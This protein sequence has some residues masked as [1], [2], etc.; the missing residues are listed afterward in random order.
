M[1]K[2]EYQLIQE[3]QHSH[4]WWLGRKAIL[5]RIIE[6]HLDLEKKLLI[7]DVGC[8]F[9]ANIPMLRQYGD[10]VGLELNK[11]ALD[12]IQQKWGGSVR[13]LIWKF[14]NPVGQK[15]DLILLADVIEHIPNDREVSD[16]IY[17]HLTDDGCAILTVPA[18]MYLWTQMDDVVHHFRRY[19]KKELEGLFLDRFTLVRCS[20]YNFILFP[21]KIAF[22]L[23]DR[24][25]N[26]LVRQGEKRSYNEVP[27][28]FINKFFKYFLLLESRWLSYFDLPYGVSLLIAVKKAKS[29]DPRAKAKL[30]IAEIPGDEPPRIGGETKLQVLRWGAAYY[31]RFIRELWF[32]RSAR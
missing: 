15:F 2:R 7:A 8:G 13:T 28:A 9:G 19:S 14:P 3:G 5:Q 16:W 12:S 21:V 25:K 31:F 11:A 24:L 1:E 10:V 20:Y 26:A 30:K 6:K 23:F 18:H 22:T 32:W 4:W 27:P 29:F 17:E